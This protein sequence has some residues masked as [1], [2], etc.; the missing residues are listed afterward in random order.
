MKFLLL[1]AFLLIPGLVHAADASPTPEASPTPALAEKIQNKSPDGKYALRIGYD[2]SMTEATSEPEKEIDSTAIQAI[3]IVSLPGKEVVRDLTDDVTSGGNNFDSLKLLWSSDS[4]WCALYF[5]FPRV[6]YTSVFH[7]DGGKWELAHKPDEL[8]VP[9]KD[10]VRN[11]H[12]A[13]V[14]WI[15]PGILELSV[16]RIYRGEAEGDGLTGFT[17]SFDGKGKFKILKKKR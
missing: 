1:S 7:L 4:K 13:P 9:T 14:R 6:G 15:K 8:N 12:I 3:A 2:S 5:S 11:E 17:A 16:E 10:D